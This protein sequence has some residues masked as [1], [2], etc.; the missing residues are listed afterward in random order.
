MKSAIKNIF[1]K[2]DMK[3][4]LKSASAVFAAAV[5]ISG[6]YFSSY[7]MTAHKQISNVSY[8]RKIWNKKG[9]SANDKFEVLRS[10][11]GDFTA[12][13]EFADK[14]V[15]NPVYLS[16]TDGFYDNHDMFKKMSRYGALHFLSGE[17]ISPYSVDKNL[18]IKGNSLSDGSM[19]GSL[20]KFK[21]SKY[22]E[23]N[24][25]ITLTTEHGIYKYYVFAVYMFDFNTDETDPTKSTFEDGSFSDWQKNISSR[26]FINTSVRVNSGDRFLTL[27]TELD[28]FDSAGLAI[29]A[30]RVNSAQIKEYSSH[31]ISTNPNAVYPYKWYEAHK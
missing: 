20:I 25:V 7:F 13:I 30:K 10:S 11:N 9:T 4:A 21:N 19:F 27:I 23:R 5:L 12:W 18:V 3:I 29:T 22:C 17:D 28:D 26:S 1:L 8:A 6:V 15:S 31:R 16:Q 14:S 24:S 2:I